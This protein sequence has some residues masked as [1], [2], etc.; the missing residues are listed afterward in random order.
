MPKSD[1]TPVAWVVADTWEGYAKVVFHRHALAA[2][3]IGAER[4]NIDYEDA[5]QRRAPKYDQ[6]ADRCRVPVSVLIDDG[7]FFEC[8]HC[9]SRIHHDEEEINIAD[10]II[11]DDESCKIYCSAECK[12][13]EADEI[14]RINKAHADFKE[15]VLK[16]R[17]DLEFTRFSNGYPSL[18][19]N[20]SFKF[21]G[22]E[23][24]GSAQ[25]NN[26]DRDTE[27]RWYVASGD[28]EAWDQYEA[29]RK[30]TGENPC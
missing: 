26:I 12:Q 17:P 1:K 19:P 23:H 22:C 6:Y 28:K 16:A 3:R 7:W 4:L 15:A 13:A 24:G 10:V 21:E 25:I 18:K 29:T 14:A 11:E 27:I 20:C 5:D 30:Q 8:Y 2:R 9:C